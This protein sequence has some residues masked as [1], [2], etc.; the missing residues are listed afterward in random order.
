MPPLSSS[1]RLDMSQALPPGYRLANDHLDVVT[2]FL[3]SHVDDLELYAE[4]PNG[5]DNGNGDCH[6]GGCGDGNCGEATATAA[7]FTSATA[8]TTAAAAAAATATATAATALRL[9]RLY[10]TVNQSLVWT[11]AGTTTLVQRYRRRFTFASFHSITHRPQTTTCKYTEQ[12]PHGF[13]YCYTPT[14]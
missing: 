3:N 6:C 13:C 1:P 7:I 11:K 10:C 5:W 12:T 4:T 14:I 8:T 2:A 9:K